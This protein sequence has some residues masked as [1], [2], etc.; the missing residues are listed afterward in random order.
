MHLKL[1]SVCVQKRKKRELGGG[2][3]RLLS[4]FYYYS[5]FPVKENW[6]TQLYKRK[7]VRIK[8]TLFRTPCEILGGL[9]SK[10]P[11]FT[12]LFQFYMTFFSL[13]PTKK[14]SGNSWFSCLIS[15]TNLSYLRLSVW[16][17]VILFSLLRSVQIS[18]DFLSFDAYDFRLMWRGVIRSNGSIDSL[19]MNQTFLL[20]LTYQ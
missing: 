3:V 1:S 9:T 8:I 7:T 19:K 6:T 17:F 16:S 13:K 5:L 2:K 14:I 4:S 15:P 10:Q 11:S 18:S 20:F 12:T